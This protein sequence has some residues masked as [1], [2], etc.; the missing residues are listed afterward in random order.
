[1]TPEAARGAAAMANDRGDAVVV[2]LWARYFC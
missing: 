1:M 2:F